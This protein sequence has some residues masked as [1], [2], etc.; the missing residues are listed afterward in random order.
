M[1]AGMSSEV[2]AGIQT[3]PPPPP[4]QRPGSARQLSYFDR[5]VLSSASRQAGQAAS[6][7]GVGAGGERG[8]GFISQT[9]RWCNYL[10]L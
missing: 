4:S 1:G 10:V 5:L 9:L 6:G 2:A 3:E 8:V 7:A